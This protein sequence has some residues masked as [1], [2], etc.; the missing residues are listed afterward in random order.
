MIF[1]LLNILYYDV[2]D[3]GEMGAWFVMSAL[4][5]FAA[6]PGSADSYV[7]SSPIFKHVAVERNNNPEQTSKFTD[8]VKDIT[9]HVLN[10]ESELQK[11]IKIKT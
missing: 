8:M 2:S 6:Q 4:G 9:K 10:G 5:I 1:K 11:V 7:L 3:N